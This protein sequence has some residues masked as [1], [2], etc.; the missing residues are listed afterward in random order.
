M[1][2]TLS[3]EIAPDP[4]ATGG[5][6]HTSNAEVFVDN[7]SFGVYGSNPESGNDG[8]FEWRAHSVDVSSVYDARNGSLIEF[9]WTGGADAAHIRRVLL[10]NTVTGWTDMGAYPN[11]FPYTA[12]EFDG[13]PEGGTGSP[14]QAFMGAGG[15]PSQ[16]SM[17]VSGWVNPGARMKWFFVGGRSPAWRVGGVWF[18]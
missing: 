6:G 11:G 3:F 15:F 4:T 1:A 12:T 13:I 10:T 2:F 9:A 5:A 16:Y 7:V 8:V 18:G 14:S 17:Q